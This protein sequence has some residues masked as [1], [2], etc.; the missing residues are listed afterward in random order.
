MYVF[1]SSL[2]TGLHTYP[3]YFII[4]LHFKGRTTW[5]YVRVRVRPPPVWGRSSEGKGGDNYWVTRYGHTGQVWSCL[6]LSPS[7]WSFTLCNYLPHCLSCYRCPMYLTLSSSVN[8]P[9]PTH[10]LQSIISIERKR[11]VMK[12]L[13]AII[14]PYAVQSVILS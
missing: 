8:S 1:I 5:A 2:G 3:T 9:V 11:L 13:V 6:F 10:P 4:M 12:E 7:P 14:L